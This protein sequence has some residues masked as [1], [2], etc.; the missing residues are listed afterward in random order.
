MTEHRIRLRGGWECIPIDS[1]ASAAYRLALP[2][3]WKPEGPSRLRLIRRFNQPRTEAGTEVVLRMEQ[4]PGIRL[5]QLNGQP[6]PLGSPD[7]SEFEIALDSSA[8]RHQLI[9]EI[10]PPTPDDSVTGAP[11]WGVVALVIRPTT[12]GTVT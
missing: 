9:L 10:E 1:T 7:R 3:R 11:E 6:T 2:T 5:L 12:P 8:A 4:V